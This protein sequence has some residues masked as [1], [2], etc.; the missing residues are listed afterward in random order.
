[1]FSYVPLWCKSNFSFLEGANHPDELVEEAQRRHFPAS[2]VS[3]PLD[4]TDD[5]QL[6]A[7]GFLKE[8][9]DPEF[10]KILFPQGAIASILGTPM[11]P[12]PRLGQHNTEILTQLGYSESD[13][14]T[15]ILA[16]AILA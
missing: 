16:G 2:P 14:K 12:A 4:L 1:M 6:I 11:S 7:R 9:D 8:I 13:C 10:G 5:P 15:L 3:T